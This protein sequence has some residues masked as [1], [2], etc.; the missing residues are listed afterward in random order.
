MEGGK[1]WE[2]GGVGEGRGGYR[3]REREG[4]VWERGGGGGDVGMEGGGRWRG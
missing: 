2:R 3:E 4:W 1:V